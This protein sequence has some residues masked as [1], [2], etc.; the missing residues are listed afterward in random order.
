[1]GFTIP[2]AVWLFGQGPKGTP[3]TPAA[4]DEQADEE[5]T[6]KEDSDEEAGEAKSGEAA[7]SKESAQG[8]E[9]EKEGSEGK[10]GSDSDESKDES[11]DGKSED[12]GDDSKQESKDEGKDEG[13]DESE[14][15]SNSK[16][17]DSKPE[18][19][20]SDDGYELP[21]PNAPGQINYKSG[22]GKGP[23]EGQKGER[24][25]TEHKGEKDVSMRTTLIHMIL[26]RSSPTTINRAPKTHTLSRTRKRRAKRAR[27]SPILP[28]ST[29]PSIRVAQ[30]G[31]HRTVSAF[32]VAQHH[33]LP[34][35][36]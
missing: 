6:E 30:Q 3:H 27:A 32:V 14:K 21:G 8:A 28:K 35:H 13:K 12:S 25:A 36:S 9:D 22:S 33:V 31:K 17:S 26:T 18:R 2:T 29:G 24:R 19:K 5:A 7:P 16:G 10:D 15:D 11:S 34:C 20:Y 23:G 4:A 1:V